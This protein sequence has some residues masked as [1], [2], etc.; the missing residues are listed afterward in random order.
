MLYTMYNPQQHQQQLQQKGW[1]F[2]QK[3]TATNADQYF[4]S[5]ITDKHKLWKLC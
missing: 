5:G 1:I 2:L 3:D 4:D